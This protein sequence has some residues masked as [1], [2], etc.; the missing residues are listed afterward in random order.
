MSGLTSY[1]RRQVKQL[2]TYK[3]ATKIKQSG[4]DSLP[5][6]RAEYLSLFLSLGL[7]GVKF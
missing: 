5:S 2:A 7:I 4:N 6:G 3:P 1:I